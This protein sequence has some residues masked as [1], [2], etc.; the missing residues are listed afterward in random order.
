MPNQRSS[1][2][3]KETIAYENLKE[4]GKTCL[5]E[6]ATHQYMSQDVVVVVRSHVS[7]LEAVAPFTQRLNP[8]SVA[9][10]VKEQFKM[11]S[12]EANLFGS[13]M[14]AAFSYCMKAGGKATNGTRLANEVKTV[15]M[16]SLDRVT[17]ADGPPPYLKRRSS[18]FG[19]SS[20]ECESPKRAKFAL[21]KSI[22][23]PSQ[24]DALYSSGS[25]S[26]HVKVISP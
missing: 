9:R 6:P 16:A 4:F 25:S 26:M 14:C 1:G 18:S 10:M 2:P 20:H 13:A 8:S 21:K 17:S 5:K 22:S 7:F 24:I 15:Y 3:S 11:S 12:I 23:S 19:L